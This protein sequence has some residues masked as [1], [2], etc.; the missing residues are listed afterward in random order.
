MGNDAE[1]FE[2]STNKALHFVRTTKETDI[3]E[4]HGR[5]SLIVLVGEVP[6]RTFV[7][8]ENEVLIGRVPEA[9][10]CVT[11]S[12]VSR[13]HA[14]IRRNPVGG[15]ILVDLSSRNGTRVNG[16][17]VQ[18][19][20]LEFGDKIFVGDS[21]VL[22][23]THFDQLGEQLRQAQKMESIG[24]LAGGVA[25]DFNNLLTVVLAN[26]SFLKSLPRSSTLGDATVSAALDDAEAAGRRAIDVTR[27]LLAF[28]R[29]GKYDERPVDVSSLIREVAR[30][31]RRTFDRGI[32]ID[33][34][35]EPDL[36][37][38][39]DRSQLD[40]VIM[41]LFINARDAMPQGGQLLV[42]ATLASHDDL[43]LPL[44][45]NAGRS[46]VAISVQDT[47]VGMSAEIRAHAFEPFFTTK[48][49][50]TGTGLGLATVYGIVKNHG[51]DVTIDSQ[52]GQGSTFKVF[53]PHAPQESA[54]SR[55]VRTEQPASEPP[56]S[57]GLVLIVDDDDLVRRGAKRLLQKLGYTVLEACD[58]LEAVD[59]YKSN[60][61]EIALV[62]LDLV[63]P[64]MNGEQTFFALKELDPDVRVL[65]TSGYTDEDRAQ[66]ISAAG[67]GGFI[68]KP[69]DASGLA[70]AMA[71]VFSKR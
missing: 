1:P 17:P 16:V 4:A 65:V 13:R 24:L 68:Q 40:Q 9:T 23:F 31:I 61:S 51:G 18:Q 20:V 6:G 43:P 15:F 32:V 33:V 46:F 14:V 60:G 54:S 69:Y 34:S 55:L 8:D 71:A 7:L 64:R 19:K 49:S 38:V 21:T 45:I 48:Q 12:E 37:V 70:Q 50:S 58:G 25:H 56:I 41:N 44:K 5:A 29:R 11:G 59:C 57:H 35:V 27:Q 42:R 36:V 30:L 39:G 63:M 62:L 2:E 22:L 28:A 52:P 3:L 66:R 47:G 53:L 26:M 10:I 67:A